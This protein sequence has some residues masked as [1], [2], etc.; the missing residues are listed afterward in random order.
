MTNNKSLGEVLDSYLSPLTA[1]GEKLTSAVRVAGKPSKKA[2]R[3]WHLTLAAACMVFLLSV[4]AFAAS[5]G[6]FDLFFKDNTDFIKDSIVEINRS[7]EKNGVLFTV[8]SAYVSE[9]G[10]YLIANFTK[11]DGTVF[12]EEQH[13]GTPIFNYNFLAKREWDFDE[14]GK[15]DPFK[16]PDL[17][18]PVITK[19]SENQK[20][21]RILMYYVESA[22]YPT[23]S[24]RTVNIQ[25]DTLTGPRSGALYKGPWS[26]QVEL[27]KKTKSLKY[28]LKYTTEYNGKAI[29]IDRV[30]LSSNGFYAECTGDIMNIRSYLS[31]MNY[32]P[33]KLLDVDDLFYS[34][35][36]IRT[37]SST[38]K[39]GKV[40]FYGLF[41]H[42]INVNE[43]DSIKI[44]D[45]VI[46]LK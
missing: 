45:D 44:K 24:G 16:T 21:V 22:D 8:E 20:S 35:T 23:L 4:T 25:F 42:P 36:F 41:S 3:Y 34:N 18:Y 32:E 1:D 10:A 40:L 15:Y 26:V 17:V 43:M 5:L 6:Y 9:A 7:D 14:F 37:C 38:E 39:D 13:N 12:G 28:D 27:P 29:T 11:T 19:L 2:S 31:K 33:D 46:P 30:S